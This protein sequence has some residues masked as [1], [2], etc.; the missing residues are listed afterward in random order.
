MIVDVSTTPRQQ[1]SA[2]TGAANVRTEQLQTSCVNVSLIFSLII[3]HETLDF[4]YR[5]TI[6]HSLCI[7][8]IFYDFIFIL[9][10]SA[11]ALRVACSGRCSGAHD[12]AWSFSG[13]NTTRVLAEVAVFPARRPLCVCIAACML[14][15]TAN[16]AR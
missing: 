10:L 2:W 6:E 5:E 1:P 8:R 7:F 14:P 4:Y 13:I 9:L 3:S 16:C 15:L 11:R 12:W